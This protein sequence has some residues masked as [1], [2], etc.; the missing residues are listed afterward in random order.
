MVWLTLS[1]VFPAGLAPD[2]E[3]LGGGQGLR[4][5]ELAKSCHEAVQGSCIVLEDLESRQA[6]RMGDP[7][8]KCSLRYSA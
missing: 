7:S 4:L 5:P 8:E 2:P 6:T 3:F 1:R